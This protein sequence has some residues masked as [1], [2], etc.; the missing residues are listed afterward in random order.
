[1]RIVNGYRFTQRDGLEGFC[2]SCKE[3]YPIPTDIAFLDYWPSKT[4]AGGF[5]RACYLELLKARHRIYKHRAKE[6]RGIRAAAFAA[7][8][9][10][11]QAR[12][13][14]RDRHYHEIRREKQ[15]IY[16]RE[17][18]MAHRDEKHA[19][20]KAYYRAHREEALAYAARRHQQ[21]RA[22]KAAA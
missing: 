6:R 10:E 21:K 20:N 19:Y 15:A 3:W 12:I 22:L 17:Y 18:R 5:C 9:P 13:R 2:P 16:Q 14:A 7:L 11:E 4:Q 1:M 8:P